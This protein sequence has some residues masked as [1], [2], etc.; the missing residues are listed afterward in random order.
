MARITKKTKND[1]V[2]LKITCRIAYP[3]L[4]EPTQYKGMGRKSYNACL[5]VQNPNEIKKFNAA[6]KYMID[7][8]FEGD[9]SDV[10]MPHQDGNKKRPGVEHFK[11][12]IFF[13]A[14]SNS[15]P[16]TYTWIGG[17]TKID[18]PLVLSGDYIIAS[19]QLYKAKDFDRIAVG[20]NNISVYK[21]T[22][23]IISGK[24]SGEEDFNDES[25]QEYTDIIEAAKKANTEEGE[26]FT[27]DEGNDDD[28]PFFDGKKSN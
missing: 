6:L 14:K 17:F 24:P 1:R 7:F 27:F 25:M 11:D 5:I 20:L 8:H 10:L 22:D 19:I 9:S 12:S 2:N 23:V 3:S 21:K 4:D 28:I 18:P 16:G 15:Q 26:G 13:S